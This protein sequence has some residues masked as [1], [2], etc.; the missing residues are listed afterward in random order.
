MQSSEAVAGAGALA[1]VF[2]LL[3]IFRFTADGARIPADAYAE[4]LAEAVDTLGGKTTTSAKGT[5]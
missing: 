2:L 4:R 5:A 1:L 3:W